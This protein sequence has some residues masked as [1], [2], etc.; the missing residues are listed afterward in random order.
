MVLRKGSLSWLRDTSKV[1]P[2]ELMSEL[3]IRSQQAFPAGW[4][5]RVGCV[6]LKPAHTICPVVVVNSTN[7]ADLGRFPGKQHPGFGIDV[8]KYINSLYENVIMIHIILYNYVLILFCLF[9][10]FGYF[11]FMYVCVPCTCLL[12]TE[13]RRRYRIPQLWAV[14]ARNRIQVLW[15]TSVRPVKCF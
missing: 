15:K 2:T 12:P 5:W 9:Y 7:P 3:S 1:L 11:V 4:L 10:V 8:S 14:G 6:C 13:A